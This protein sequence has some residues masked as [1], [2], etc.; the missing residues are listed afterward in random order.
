MFKTAASIL[1]LACIFSGV[2]GQEFDYADQENWGGACQ[3]G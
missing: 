1:I 2:M 3:N